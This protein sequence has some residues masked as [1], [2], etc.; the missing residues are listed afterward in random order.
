VESLTAIIHNSLAHT[1]SNPLPTLQDPT[2]ETSPPKM[3][4]KALQQTKA[5]LS[6]GKTEP[7]TERNPQEQDENVQTTRVSDQQS[8]SQ[9]TNEN[10]AQNTAREDDTKP[11]PPQSLD[12]H[13]LSKQELHVDAMQVKMLEA[14]TELSKNSHND[15]KDKTLNAVDTLLQSSGQTLNSGYSIVHFIA[16]NQLII[17]HSWPLLLAILKRVAENNDKFFIPTAFKCVQL[18]CTDF[19]SNFQP[20]HLALFVSCAGYILKHIKILKYLDISHRR[21]WQAKHRYKYRSSLLCG[22][23]CVLSLCFVVCELS[24]TAYGY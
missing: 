24:M 1:I 2:L 13:Q 8:N 21:V 20:H 15:V 4:E 16:N 11:Y 17:I 10:Y 6:Q 23:L 12:G 3:P 9:N 19:L 14:L 18:I 5:S 7:V 22:C